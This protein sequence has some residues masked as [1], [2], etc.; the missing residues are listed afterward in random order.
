MG[1]TANVCENRWLTAW[2]DAL[3]FVAGLAIARFAGWNTGDLIWS[4]WLSSLVV[5]YTMIVWTI[6]SRAWGR[7]GEMLGGLFLLA[8]FT[9]H[10]GM[11]HFVHS[12][13]LEQ[14]FPLDGVRGE[15]GPDYL[16]V[17][18]RYAIWLPVAFFAERAAFRRPPPR[19]D[20]VSVNAGDIEARKARDGGALMMKPYVNVIRLHLLI[21]FFAFAHAMKWESFAIYAVVYAVYFF[22]WRLVLKS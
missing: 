14:F 3:A 2:P 22:P 19:V 15:G 6:F 7:A 12:M 16:E 21:F 1:N 5:G 17:V 9:V 11:F 8:F 10:F 20:N 4:L 13:F 18:A